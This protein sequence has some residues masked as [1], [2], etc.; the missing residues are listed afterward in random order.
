MMQYSCDLCGRV[1][2]RERYEAKVEITAAFDPDEITEGDLDEDHLQSIAA[3]I[4]E[5]E[6]TGEFEIEETGPRKL[7]F[8]LCFHCMRRFVRDPL[9]RESARRLNFSQN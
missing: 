5:L 1:M 8:D 6:H 7:R 9:G 4:E 2:Q 3:S